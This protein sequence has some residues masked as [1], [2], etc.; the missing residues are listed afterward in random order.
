MGTNDK[1][2]LLKAK[3]EILFIE[4]CLDLLAPG[5]RMGIV[6]PEGVLNNPSL[7]YVRDYCEDR[8]RIT[9]VVSLPQ[10]TFLST[11][12]TVKA[13]L[14]FV[15]KHTER[16]QRRYDQLRRAA[17]NRATREVTETFR[18]DA[19]DAALA[20][21]SLVP[22]AQLAKLDIDQAAKAFAT[23]KRVPDSEERKALRSELKALAQEAH[24]EIARR[25]RAY[26]K[27]RWPYYVFLYDADRVGITATGDEDLNELFPNA[28]QPEGTEGLTALEVYRDF[29]SNPG[30]YLLG[31]ER[32][33][34][35]LEEA[36]EAQA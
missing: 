30:A 18:G 7:Q 17:T 32:D 19:A 12:A 34:V 11:G 29:C 4:R 14:L 16:E 21:A 24:A 15:T 28:R 1:G 9:A 26:L 2:Q 36:A 8:A 5:G 23:T 3:T 22:Q 27:A 33:D 10:E 31:Q 13:S 25:A 6:L 35:E 20:Y